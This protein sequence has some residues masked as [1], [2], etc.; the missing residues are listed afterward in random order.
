MENRLITYC[1]Q[2]H[3]YLS[4]KITQDQQANKHW[5]N[6]VDEATRNSMIRNL[7]SANSLK[8]QI[9]LSKL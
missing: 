7:S 2:Q 6:G 8:T 1:N 3:K 9:P 4:D 5:F